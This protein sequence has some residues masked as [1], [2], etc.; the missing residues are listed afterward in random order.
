MNREIKFRVWH[1]IW[2]KM[3]DL[4]CTHYIDAKEYGDPIAWD[5]QDFEFM[6]FT[7][8]R[9]KNG[10]EIYEGDIILTQEYKSRP[11]SG[12]ASKKRFY[13][14][15]EYRIGEGNFGVEGKRH[16]MYEAEWCV[17]VPG[18]HDKHS[19]GNW[20]DFFDCEVVGNIYENPE[21]LEA[22]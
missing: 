12:R 20:G 22:K 4:D 3:F 7:G 15:V 6:Q 9:D 11:Y 17:K 19:C 16:L 8:L 21:L 18:G 10:K 13:G 2:K 14:G 5:D 1:K